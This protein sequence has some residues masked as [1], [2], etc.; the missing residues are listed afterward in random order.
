MSSKT[1]K[2]EYVAEPKSRD[3]YSESEKIER[4]KSSLISTI[5]RF[6]KQYGGVINLILG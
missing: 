5:Q 2:K 3:Y 6:T 4:I 1:I